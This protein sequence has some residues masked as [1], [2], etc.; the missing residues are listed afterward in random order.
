MGGWDTLPGAPS[1]AAHPERVHLLRREGGHGD[2]LDPVRRIDSPP[3]PFNICTM[4]I[5]TDPSTAIFRNVDEDP[6]HG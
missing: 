1:V 5:C 4:Y 3:T 2:G 6:E